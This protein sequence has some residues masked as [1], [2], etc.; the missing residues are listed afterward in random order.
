ML[1]YIS[2]TYPSLE[3]F[4]DTKVVFRSEVVSKKGRQYNDQNKNDKKT[5]ND[6][7]NTTQKSKY[8]ATRMSI[9]SRS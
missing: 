1:C 7:R 5:N 6:L 3:M 4:E 9:K 2:T 8:Q